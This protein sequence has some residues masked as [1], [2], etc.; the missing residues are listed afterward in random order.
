VVVAKIE[1]ERAAYR[2]WLM[3]VRQHPH[4]LWWETVANWQQHWNPQ[5][6]DP[7]AMLDQALQNSESRR[8]WQTESWQP[9]A[10]M[11][12]FW[13]TDAT[14]VRALYDD[15]FNETKT[16]EGRVSRFIFGLDTLLADYKRTHATRIENNHYHSDYR[17]IAWYLACQ[18]P[19]T[20]AAPYDFEVFATALQRLGAR[21]LPQNNDPVRYF[22][23]C[24]TLMTFLEKD[25]TVAQAMQRHLSPKRH[26]N[27][28]SLLLAADFCFFIA[29]R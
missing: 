7:A 13:Q 6:A 23:V 17:L 15:L 22:K 19:D 16:I 3:S 27:G 12:R 24:R 28:K 20:Y 21:D 18:Y 2:D 4:L 26:F 25:P 11:Q 9:K 1:A 8:L 29:K 5:A 10:M 14:M